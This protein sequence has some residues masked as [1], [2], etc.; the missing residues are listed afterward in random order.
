MR[1]FVQRNNPMIRV[2]P[3]GRFS[4]ETAD[5]AAMSVFAEISA[6]SRETENPFKS[7]LEIDIQLAAKRPGLLPCV[8]PSAF[9]LG[10]LEAVSK[11]REFY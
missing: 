4:P 8:P 5:V 7:M 1:Q 6:P 10:S 2:E 3:H 11:K 9:I